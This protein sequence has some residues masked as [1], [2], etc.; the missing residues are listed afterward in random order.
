MPPFAAKG[1]DAKRVK[2]TVE[3]L[4]ESRVQ[5]DIASDADEF[6]KAMDRAYR[7]VAKQI[8]IPGF[9]PGK[10]PRQIIEARVGHHAMVHEAHD[11]LMDDLFRKALQ[12]ENI[13]P[14]GE[15]EVTLL[16]HEPLEFRVV[17]PVY[18]EIDLGNYQDVRVEP[19]D[20]AI[21]DEEVEEVV[22]R[23]RKGASEWVEVTEERTP[24]EGDQ[25]TVDLKVEENGEPF[26]EPVE[27][28]TFVLGESNI[29]DR[30]RE[31]IETMKVG[32]TS[33]ISLDFAEDDESV[34]PEIRGKTL[35]YT[36]M[37]KAIKVRDL[38][39]VDDEFAKKV[40]DVETV[41]ELYKTIA[42]DLHRAKTSELRTEVVNEAINAIGEQAKIELPAVMIDQQV[43]DEI[44]DLRQRL[45]Q[46]GQS[47]EAYLRANRQTEA[48]LRE[49]IRPEATRRLRNT[50]ILQEIA[51]REQITVS[52]EE[53]DA[54]I[55]TATAGA[56]NSEAL[57]QL[58]NQDRFR[59]M[60][61]NDLF[62][63]KLTDRVIEIVTEGKGAVINGWVEPEVTPE[64][65]ETAEP[66]EG[67]AGEEA[68][69]EATATEA[70]A[71]A[72]AVVEA[73]AGAQPDAA[74]EAQ[75]DAAAETVV[76]TGETPARETT[77]EETTAAPKEAAATSAAEGDQAARSE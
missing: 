75:P 32:E 8:N 15:P 74:A 47:L 65:T 6:A 38:V 72:R 53:I 18:P 44:N 3:R 76:A 70:D 77:T 36:I 29:F 31:H 67:A 23:L 57:R 22:Q 41:E 17:V 16:E 43:E 34:S 50:L 69:P 4:P 14:I 20:A 49:E 58:Y 42:D 5:L 26:Q 27:D 13:T 30:L 56:S 2:V 7:R 62:E 54:Q 19:R 33:R 11:E 60:L 61:R 25:V 12:Q 64:P 59:Q 66:T 1:R 37:L 52:D 55:A 35:D 51:R 40:G 48:E 9:R 21:T 28:A 24:Q 45:A 39:E 71:A 63:R 68:S 73:V 10:A 46:S